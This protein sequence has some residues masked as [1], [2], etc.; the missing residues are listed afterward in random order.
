VVGIAL[1]LAG[2]GFIILALGG[3]LRR[4]ESSAMAPAPDDQRQ[5]LLVTDDAVW[6]SV[7]E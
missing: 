3:G 6:A 4:P 2:L 1:I 7:R 5:A